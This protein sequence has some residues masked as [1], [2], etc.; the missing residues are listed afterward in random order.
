MKQAPIAQEQILETFN[1]HFE[2]VVRRDPDRV[3]VRLKTPEG[4]TSISYG[5][6]YRR[7]RG[8]A[9][10]LRALGLER[11]CRV[12]IL[13]E[14]RPEWVVAYLGSY[15][16]GTIA[17]PLDTQ[18]SPEEWRRLIDDSETRV[19]FVSGMLR[20]KLLA[21]LGEE[22]IPKEKIISFDTTEDGGRNLGELIEWAEGLENPPDPGESTLSDAVTII[23]TS[24]TTGNP[25]GVLLTQTNVMNEMSGIFNVVHIDQ[26]DAFLCLLPLQ[27]VL[28][29]I[30]NV[31]VPLYK[32][33][34]VVFADTLKRAE[35]LQ[36]LEEA[37]ITFLVTVPQ[38]FY[39]FYNRI[40]DELSKK[41]ILIRWMF[42]GMLSLN[43]FNLR[44]LKLNAGR[45]FF[46]R[47]HRS[48]GS[49]LRFFVS[50]GSSIDAKVARDFYDMGFTILQG[51]GLTETSG[52]CAVTRPSNN[53]IGSVGWAL[54]SAEIKILSPNEA[55]I[56]EIL[57]R[58]GVV[59]PGYYKNPEATQA[60][61]NEGWFHSGDLGLVDARGNLFITGRKK[62]V[63]VLANGKNIY[64]DEVETHY[65]QCPYIQEIAVI[66]VCSEQDRS[67]KLHAVVV[68]NFEYLKSKKIANTREILRDEIAALS[69]RLPKYKRLM[70]YQIQA[71]PLPRTT[72]KKIKRL[73]IKKLIESGQL[74]AS[75]RTA[76]DRAASAADISAADQA[77][78][79]SPVGQ[80]VLNCLRAAYKREE[81]ITPDMN[82]E[83]DL[84]FDSM[85]RVELI[86]S[87]EQQLNIQLP[88][89]VAAEIFTVRDLMT[90]V[91]QASHR[92]S[93]SVAARQNW[94]AILA[95]DEEDA[96][97]QP[98]GAALS[99]IK[100]LAARTLYFTLCK[101]LLRLEVRGLENLPGEG[102]YLICPNHQSFIDPFVLISSM[103]FRV[104]RK[105]FFV[106]YSAF[107]NGRFMRFIARMVNTIPVDPDA[108]LLRAMKTGAAGLRQGGILCIFPE[109]GRSFDGEVQEFRKGASILSRELSAPMIPAAI[110]GA[111]DVWARGS[112]RI[113]PHKVRIAFGEMLRPAA[114]SNT[115]DPYQ[116]E[117]DRLKNAVEKLFADLRNRR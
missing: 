1:Q 92:S 18:I 96:A 101:P 3:A 83:L 22:T 85:E 35:I 6:V 105:M 66:G 43:R 19:V 29:S 34:C 93:Q 97:F 26:N 94:D 15:F 58:G 70:S 116:E 75:D 115:D 86:S 23:Y 9:G 90:R 45:I 110:D 14:N 100:Y 39:L 41:S 74:L 24:G 72:T 62:E 79:E 55:G 89:D 49:K 84:G 99:F 44:F 28:A 76:S 87:L 52:A 67:E 78:M 20:A 38:F 33:G 32:G 31:L 46:G 56:G 81:K 53:A 69:N 12:A 59:T 16:A 47:I 63:I 54:S 71:E 7:I 107:F 114:V 112:M 91:D 37:G 51:Y 4:Y 117:L 61:F 95:E 80:D 11:G 108:H 2:K 98:S 48:F 60:A 25:K 50:G 103:P 36:A 111:Y 10:A 109:G 102:P 8:V 17:V 57:I 42:R 106:G 65:L 27:H 40:Q 13:S 30:I 64:P 82:L 73:E 77:L 21:A 113:R 104:F 88:E 5:E 68:P